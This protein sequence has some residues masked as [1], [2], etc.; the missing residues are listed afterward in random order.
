MLSSSAA[1]HQS[2]P[3]PRLFTLVTVPLAAKYTGLLA[4]LKYR[5]PIAIS[6]GGSTTPKAEDLREAIAVSSWTGYA[7]A[8]RAMRQHWSQLVWFRWLYVV[9]SRYMWVNEWVELY[10]ASVARTASEAGP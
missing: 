9:F 2:E 1:Q 3:K 7:R 4:P 6:F 5:S 10:P 8:H